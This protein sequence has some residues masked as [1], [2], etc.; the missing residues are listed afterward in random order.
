MTN[1][2][3]TKV[4]AELGKADV[5]HYDFG[6][7]FE[8]IVDAISLLPQENNPG[9]FLLISRKDLAKFQKNLK[10]ALSYTEDFVRTGAIGAIAG[11]P[12]YPTDALEAG[13]A[14]LATKEAVTCFV[15]KG[16]ETEQERDANI[17]KTTIYGRNV[18]VIALTNA[19]KVVKL[20]TE[21]EPENP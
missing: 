2:V 17:R 7:T 11:V 13:T 1:D 10:D 12:V 20:T 21:A 5:V 6:F 9:L 19:A 16:V 4:V 14:F 8:D 15:K 3:T 18:K